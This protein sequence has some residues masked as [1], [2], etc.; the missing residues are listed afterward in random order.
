MAVRG[1]SAVRIA[2]WTEEGSF[3]IGYLAVVLLPPAGE[4]PDAH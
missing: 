1:T 2:N 3:V 4:L